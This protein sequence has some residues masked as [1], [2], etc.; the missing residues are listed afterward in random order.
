MNCVSNGIK[1]LFTEENIKE[2]EKK[3]RNNID[4]NN[5]NN[6]LHNNNN[7]ELHQNNNNLL[8]NNKLVLSEG[9]VCSFSLSSLS[10]TIYKENNNIN[11]INNSLLNNNKNIDNNY[12][13]EL[14]NNNNN[15]EDK[16]F[17]YYTQ[18]AS[19]SHSVDEFTFFVC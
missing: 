15:I 1:Y 14:I 16:Y 13:T 9:C 7:N 8:N 11:N 2:E 17:L 3:V 19:L 6:E 12:N 10:F 4:I 5:N 18:K